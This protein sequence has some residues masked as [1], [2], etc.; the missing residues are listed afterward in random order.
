MELLGVVLFQWY[1]LSV[2]G[3][4]LESIQESIV[5][6]RLVSKGFFKGPWVPV[7]GIGGLSGYFLGGL[8]KAY[9]VAVFFAGLVICTAAEY[10]TSIFLEKCFGVKCWDYATYPHTRWCQF[11][12]RVCLTISA[13]FGVITLVVVYFYWDFGLALIHALGK[14]FWPLLALLY[15]IFIADVVYSVSKYLRYK[16]LGIKI[17]SWAV[18]SKSEKPE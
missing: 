8:F 5:R 14:F 18:F 10:L 9:P 1:L 4:V 11:Q 3:W 13:F 12:G 16:K 17:N 15:A 2:T 6:R 7:H